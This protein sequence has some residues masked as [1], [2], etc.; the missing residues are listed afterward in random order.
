MAHL[1]IHVT[2]YCQKLESLCWNRLILSQTVWVYFGNFDEVCYKNYRLLRKNG[3]ITLFKVIQGHWYWHHSK[4][5]MQFDILLAGFN[6]TSDE[7]NLN[8]SLTVHACRWT[9]T[10]QRMS[11]FACFNYDNRKTVQSNMLILITA[12]N[13]IAKMRLIGS[14]NQ[15]KS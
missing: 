11:S 8:A 3:D 9:I 1:R 6:I 15:A 7:I 12:N 10:T 5:R 4:A 13:K 2:S 14:H